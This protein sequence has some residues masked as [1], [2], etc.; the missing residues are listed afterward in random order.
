MRRVCRPLLV[1]ALAVA[2]LALPAVAG[3]DHATRPHTPNIHAKGHSPHPATFEGEPDGVR[4]IS[5]DI[6]FQGSLAYNGNYDGWRVIDIADPDNPVEL[7][8]PS[9]NGDQGDISV[10]GNVLV[11]SLISKQPTPRLFPYTTLLAFEN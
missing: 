1:G 5:S 10:Y 11:C 9:C 8:H 3:A 4:H 2:M 7:A 6:A